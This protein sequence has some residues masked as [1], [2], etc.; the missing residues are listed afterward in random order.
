[1]RIEL[2]LWGDFMLIDIE[3]QE[4]IKREPL[5][6][7]KNKR[8]PTYQLYGEIQIEKIQGL[9]A[10]KIAVLETM[11][12]ARKRFRELDIP[13]ELD[14]PEPIDY[15]LVN[16]NDFKSFRI[17]KGYVVE[18]VY[19]KDCENGDTIWSFHLMEPDLG[20][21]PGNT[22]QERQPVA[23]RVFETNIAFT[24]HKG[25][26]QCGFKTICSEPENINIHCEVFRMAVV[27]NIV[28]NKLLGLNQVYPIIEESRI[29]D[30]IDR[31][32]R[33]KDF[34]MNKD[35]QLPIVIIAEYE[36]KPN[37]P[38]IITDQPYYSYR[39]TLPKDI[40]TTNLQLY[41]NNIKLPIDVEKISK[42]YMG[43][44]QF[45]ILKLGRI[46][47]YNRLMGEYN[48]KEG[49][50]RIIHPLNNKEESILFKLDEIISCPRVVEDIHFTIQEYPKHKIIDYNNI[51]F[52]NEARIEEQQKIIRMSD[53][54]ESISNAY[55]IAI[56]ELEELHEEELFN[57]NNIIES[58]N[59]II[60]SLN[61]KINDLFT[62]IDE[63]V[64]YWREE[65]EKSEEKLLKRISQLEEEI[66]RKDMLLN[67]PTKP[68]D[69]PKW[70]DDNFSGKLIFHNK[71]IDLI[72]KV[73]SDEID[74]NLLCDAIEFLAE[75]YRDERIGTITEVEKNNICKRKYN[76][77]FS[78]TP[79]GKKSIEYYTSDY[80]I[81]YKVKSNGKLG[82][83]VLDLHLKVG[84]GK[85]NLLRIYFYYD[86][87]IDLVVV[88]SLPYHLKSVYKAK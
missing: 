87:D 6:L 74:M 86:R 34:A 42:L 2:I 10:F 20:P 4:V 30:T 49:D 40:I 27:K 39:S 72:K 31:V 50:V 25:K 37:L 5:K 16:I 3:K 15:E 19:I 60:A 11:S 9:T 35:R 52:L 77:P 76:R 26:V 18:V 23:G 71:A 64:I 38:K 84:I 1:M 47:E 24:L 75:E 53:S 70:V 33:F 8:Y 36:E 54:K 63:K 32:K 12:W 22:D 56:E 51:R 78:V 13:P 14:F 7:L 44:A 29:I 59:D 66:K 48:M 73:R 82:E 45:S 68:E 41:S 21:E 69:I 80:K 67:R 55:E 83:V 85:E 46:A 81:K 28:R 62:E 43:Y 17:N 58:K 61:L 65:K 57:L 88:G 79:S